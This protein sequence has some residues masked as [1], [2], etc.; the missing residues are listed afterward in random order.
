M[1]AG[2]L[3]GEFE[4]FIA[5]SVGVADAAQGPQFREDPDQVLAPISAPDDRQGGVHRRVSFH[6]SCRALRS[7]G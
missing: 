4:G 2:R 3:A 1:K 6:R 7:R 5:R